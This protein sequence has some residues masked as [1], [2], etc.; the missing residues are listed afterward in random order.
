MLPIITSKIIVEIIDKG[1]DIKIGKDI[2]IAN[3][4][5][6]IASNF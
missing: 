2:P 4:L 6:L 5:S 1:F 3:N